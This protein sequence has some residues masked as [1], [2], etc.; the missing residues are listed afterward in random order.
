M[1]D[2]LKDEPWIQVRLFF[3]LYHIKITTKIDN[4]YFFIF[5]L[6]I[7]VSILNDLSVQIIIIY[8]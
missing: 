6:N 5:F 1:K 4:S 8:F 2:L 7:A 3:I